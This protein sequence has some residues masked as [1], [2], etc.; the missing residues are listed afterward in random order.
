MKTRGSNIAINA[1]GGQAPQWI[2]LLPAGKF[3]GRDGRGPWEIKDPAA[4]IKATMAHQ[5][6]ADLPL[7]YEHQSAQAGE[8]GQPAPAAGW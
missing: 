2:H 6:G 5:A 7:D 4:F 1:Q 3:T 8:N